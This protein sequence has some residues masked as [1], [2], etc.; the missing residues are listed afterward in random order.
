M[1]LRLGP[2]SIPELTEVVE[3]GCVS[4]VAFRLTSGVL[5]EGEWTSDLQRRWGRGRQVWLDGA[6]LEG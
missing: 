2:F 3:G 1:Y 4:K 5:Y 6:L